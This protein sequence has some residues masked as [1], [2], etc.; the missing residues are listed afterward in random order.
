MIRTQEEIVERIRW[1]EHNAE[2]LFGTRFQTIVMALDFEHAKPWLQPH[3]TKEIWDDGRETPHKEALRYFEFAIEKADGH[4]G[5]SA[6]RSLD[7]FREW[8]WLL[9]DKE[10]EFLAINSTNYGAPNLKFAAGALG[11][12]WKKN[13]SRAVKR[14]AKGKSC[15]RGCDE[16]CGR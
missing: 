7:H 10:E 1:I 3:V 16:G 2:D 11:Y 14:M 8:L 6:V 5:L 4:R 15:R 9:T 13:A 12:D